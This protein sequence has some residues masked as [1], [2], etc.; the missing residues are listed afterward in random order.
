VLGSGQW[1]TTQAPKDGGYSQISV[2]W[3]HSCALKDGSGEIFCW[4]G[5]GGAKDAMHLTE[6]PTGS[7]K[8]VAAGAFATCAID[9]FD[10]L[11][12]WGNANDGVTSNPP[13]GAYVDVAVGG[14]RSNNNAQHACGIKSDG[15]M[16]CWG[17]DDDFQSTVNPDWN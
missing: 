11:V 3:A 5:A 7:Y 9:S 14:D 17:N 15:K 10:E 13:D 6:V 8:R 12:C 4:G 16:V 2:G 1:G